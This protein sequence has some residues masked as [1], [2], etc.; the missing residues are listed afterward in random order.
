VAEW[1]NVLL[2]A[3][4]D[5]RGNA[6]KEGDVAQ[7]LLCCIR[8]ALNV[9]RFCQIRDKLWQEKTPS[10]A[11]EL[12]DQLVQVAQAELANSRQALAVVSR[13]SRLGYANSSN[14]ETI[15]VARGGINSPGTIEKKIHQVERLLEDD[16]PDYRRKRGL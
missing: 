5:L 3:G 15:G 4:P 12:I 11:S 16:I 1:E 7:N 13:D 6:R 10:V 2:S 8:S 9:G 14:G